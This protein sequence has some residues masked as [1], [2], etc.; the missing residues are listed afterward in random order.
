[1]KPTLIGAAAT[2]HLL[3]CKLFIIQQSSR[4]KHIVLGRF[5][6]GFCKF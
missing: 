5:R 1:M 6:P 3:Y 4:D 2:M